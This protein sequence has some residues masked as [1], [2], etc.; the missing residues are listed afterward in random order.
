MSVL[1]RRASEIFAGTTAGGR[2]RG[3]NIAHARVWG[4][5]LERGLISYGTWT[6]ALTFETAGNQN[7]VLSNATGNYVKFG[8]LYVFMF[9][10]VTS[11]FTHTTASGPLRIT[12][13][14]VTAS[15]DELRGALAQYQ[16]IT[17]ANYTR[18]SVWAPDGATYL[19]LAGS[20]SGQTLDDTITT[21]D[22][23]TGG[24]VTF[25][26]SVPVMVDHP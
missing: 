12:G 18:Y 24:S 23:P 21:A 26:G 4:I 8:R 6:P 11:T 9:I 1:T 20:G 22:L 5:E 19:L 3:P 14:P 25:R 7:I 15:S 10:A 13:L 2:T 16:G 17:K